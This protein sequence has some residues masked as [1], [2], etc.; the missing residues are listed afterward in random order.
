MKITLTPRHKRYIA[1][2]VKSGA[3][4]SPEE[5]LYEGLRL[6]E[7][8]D[9]RHRRIAWLQNEVEKGFSGPSTP[10]TRKDSDRVR[11]LIAARVGGQR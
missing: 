10:W 3:Y 11:R 5:V 2:K 7:A 9:E 6:L 1:D 8:E 4:G